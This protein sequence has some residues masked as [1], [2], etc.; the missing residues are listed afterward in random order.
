M[1]L[2][3]RIGVGDTYATA[4]LPAVLVFGLGLSATVAPVTAT[5]LAAADPRHSGVAS[6]V[7]NAV[8]RAAQLL[9]VAVLPVAAGLSGSDY[10]DP[11]A[12]AD[13]FHAAMVISAALSALGGALAWTTIRDDVLDAAAVGPE[14]DTPVR[15]ATDRQCPIAGTMLRPAREAACRSPQAR[16]RGGRGEAAVAPLA[17]GPAATRRSTDTE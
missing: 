3:T 11:S 15:A 4:V 8:A 12:M 13:G 17:A 16:V 9:A 10:L 5:V 2:M 14:G 6:G 1:L 7:N